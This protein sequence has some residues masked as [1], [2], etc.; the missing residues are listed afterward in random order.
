MGWMVIELMG[1][2]MIRNVR[3][4]DFFY[5]VILLGCRTWETDFSMLQQLIAKFCW[6]YQIV[7]V[8]IDNLPTGWF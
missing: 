4:S 5:V 1:T 2:A 8:Q 7:Y 6:F 3:E